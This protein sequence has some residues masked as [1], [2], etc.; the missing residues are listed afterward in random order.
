MANENDL[1]SIIAAVEKK[2]DLPSGLL[3]TII[4]SNGTGISPASRKTILDIYGIDARLN[5]A[6]AVEAA[7]ILLND[8]MAKN[9]GDEALALAEYR[10]G[11]DR[12][13][14]SGDTKKFV[15][16]VLGKRSVHG[17]NM[18]QTGAPQRVSMAP[19]PA[20]DMQMGEPTMTGSGVDVAKLAQSTGEQQTFERAPVAMAA[21]APT[22]A[23]AAP[24]APAMP[25][26]M[27]PPIPA[28]AGEPEGPHR[29][30]QESLDSYTSGEMP[31]NRRAEMRRLV[32]SGAL[33]VPDG[34]SLEEPGMMTRAGAAVDQAAGAIGE[35]VTGSQRRT[36]T[37][38]AASDITM[39]PEWRAIEGSG[40]A[41]PIKASAVVGDQVKGAALTVADALTG[42]LAG[43][44]KR[45]SATA[46]SPAEQF[47]IILANNPNLK[48]ETDEKGNRF[49]RSA[50]GQIYSEQPGLRLTDVPRIA[51]NMAAFIPAGGATTV[52]G[53]LLANAGTQ[54]ALEAAQAASGGEFNA[55]EVVLAGLGGA[56]V[57]AAGKIAAG[58]K[59]AR[60]AVPAAAEAVEVVAK[61]A[62]IDDVKLADL[63]RR[64]SEGNTA[65]TRQLAEAV[66]V[67]PAAVESAKRLGIEL[68]ADVFSESEQIRS[69]LGGV[70]G[71][72]GSEAE[73]A[74]QRTVKEASDKADE[75][76]Q[77]FDGAPS[78]GAVS[79]KVLASLQASR[80][81]LKDEAK[82]LYQSVDEVIKP[83]APVTLDNV[84]EVIK[85][86]LKDLDGDASALSEGERMMMRLAERGR[87]NPD[88]PAQAGRAT[89]EA[90]KR[91]KADL[92]RAIRMGDGPFMSNDQRRLKILER[93][94]KDDE[95]A[96]AER[97]GG[98]VVRDK[99]RLA[100]QMTAK[101][102]G[103]EDRMIGAFGRDKEGSVAALMQGAI[104]DASKGN[105]ARLTK[106]L[107]AV[108]QDLHGEV[109]MTAL[110]SATRAKQGVAE[111]G[112]GF[113]EFAKTYAG[114][115][116]KGNE[117]IFA[118]L[119]K[120]L[121]PERSA[122]LR[123]LFE[124]SKRITSARANVKQTGKA[125]QP[126]MQALEAESLVQRIA[127][128]AMG[129]AAAVG[130]GGGAGGGLGAVGANAL[131]TSIAKGD[132]DV[133]A[134][135][136]KL[137]IS[138]EFS[139]LAVDLVTNPT[140][141]PAAVRKVVMS[142]RW[143]DFVKAA[144]MPRDPKSGEQFLTAAIQAARQTRG[145]Q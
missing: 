38:E 139:A 133:V 72:I 140:V 60:G 54:A 1:S 25:E 29:A 88:M 53:A 115:R 122:A 26:G 63:A 89:H 73:A 24:S 40:L 86:S 75:V 107:K 7:G 52:G 128:S 33:I 102:K 68:P 55:G 91:V 50:N 71:K 13:S 136:G 30:R 69:A 49:F 82:A 51:A 113:S 14:W 77:A 135:V 16:G 45:L 27:A 123:D 64:A 21:A 105:S 134:K 125:N 44:V 47:Q 80:D 95:L 78:P 2:Q 34:F 28:A 61:G 114:L 110:S 65:A 98:A 87:V 109:L 144:K 46:A 112:F 84:D 103:L 59:A 120:S 11:E 19:A 90:L 56:A 20:F 8:A 124:I 119:S 108:P 12:T 85:Q 43:G 106:L 70:R 141:S 93:A 111:A 58:V 76:V 42:G 74:W 41:G 22:M 10:S 97:I 127:G 79:D 32:Q 15:S 36:A 142:Q 131:L 104:A 94:I 143:R 31:A 35:M 23:A 5:T 39:S 9:K 96:N 129:K 62:P 117:P 37:T 18:A 17:V 101:Q 81:A 130:I 138:P 92:Q 100:H 126:F 132:K 48:P 137:L 6:N 57:P 3:Q 118:Q 67:D 4:D 83:S 66:A 116:A 99:V 145:D 121:G